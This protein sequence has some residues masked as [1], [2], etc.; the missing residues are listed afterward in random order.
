MP[1]NIQQG[2]PSSESQGKVEY[3]FVTI[4]LRSTQTQRNS[5][6]S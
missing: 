3:L 4:T 1:L 6:Y 2:G 5:T